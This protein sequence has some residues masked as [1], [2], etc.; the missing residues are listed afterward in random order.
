MGMDKRFVIKKDAETDVI[1][2]MEYEKLKGLKMKP[3]RDAN[4][5]DMIKVDE[6]VVINPSLIEKL[7]SKKCTRNF[8]KIVK[9]MSIIYDDDSDDDSGYMLILD[10]IERFRNLIISK[11]KEYMEEKEYNT[12]LKKLNLLKQEIEYRKSLILEMSFDYENSKK[13]KSAR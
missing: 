11:Y 9:M 7:I 6:V 5:E 2:Y 3:K 1:T 8:K 10:E 13:G 4:F 12:L